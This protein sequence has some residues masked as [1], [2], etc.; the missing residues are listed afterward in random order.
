[1]TKLYLLPV[2]VRITRN[3]EVNKKWVLL[4]GCLEHFV[5]QTERLL[6][7]P[8]KINSAKMRLRD[9]ILEYEMVYGHDSKLEQM[10]NA[11]NFLRIQSDYGFSLN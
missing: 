11:F 9:M 5:E 8:N 10:K 2:C 6:D 1:M 3:G 7:S 4:H